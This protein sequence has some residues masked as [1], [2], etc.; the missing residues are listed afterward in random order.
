V[1]ALRDSAVDLQQRL[2][3]RERTSAPATIV[4]IDER[5]LAAYGQWPWPRS[6]LAALLERIHAAQPAA[7]GLDLLFPE[8]DRYSPAA[9]AEAL[10]QIPPDVSGRLR[11]LPG[12]DA[13]LAGAMRGRPVVLAVA[14][15]ERIDDGTPLPAF[16]SRLASIAELTRAAAGQGLISSAS[17]TRV[18][19]RMPVA[20]RIE[21]TLVP[22]LA[23]EMFRVATRAPAFALASRPDGLLEAAV[24]DIRVPAQADGLAWLRF[25][26]HDPLRYVSAAAVLEGRADP[27]LL[28]SKL[29]LIG[30]TGLGLVDHVETP[31]GERVPGVEL[32]AQLIEQIFDGTFLVRPRWAAWLEAGMLAA[33]VLVLMLVVPARRVTVSV[34]VFAA[35]LALIA[36]AA[37]GA[38]RLKGVLLDAAMPMLGIALSFGLLLAATLASFGFAFTRDGMTAFAAMDKLTPKDQFVSL[39]DFSP[40]NSLDAI[41]R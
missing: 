31:L 11:A 18:V 39:V 19:R 6:R 26:R 7:V 17:A 4:E 23:L 33:A 2:S 3:P 24:G 36:A 25:S 8:P 12:N 9:L 41:P 14:G 13:L 38:F 32:H 16:S 27:E 34:A 30:V 37:L 22:A 21:G 29:V 5:S 15:L 20:G 28:R 1:G 35:L 10:P 40:Q